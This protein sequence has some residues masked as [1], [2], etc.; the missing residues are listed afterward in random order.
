MYVFP[1]LLSYIFYFVFY[2][3]SMASLYITLRFS[4]LS[5]IPP[6]S[7]S[8]Y[9]QKR[10]RK[11]GTHNS[12]NRLPWSIR[13][14]PMLTWTDAACKCSWYFLLTSRIDALVQTRIS[15][16]SRRALVDP[17]ADERSE[18]IAISA[19]IERIDQGR[20]ESS[21]LAWSDNAGFRHPTNA[22]ATGMSQTW[23]VCG[24]SYTRVTFSF[25][26]D[27]GHKDC[28]PARQGGPPL[29]LWF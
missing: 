25:V 4:P 3:T 20:I 16:S 19:S 6:S 14:C 27:K 8:C 21:Q 1:V 2:C 23:L 29:L 17:L 10:N 9:K 7:A 18:G 13:V 11:T 22:C 28:V 24:I 15:W 26:A 12:Q 5:R